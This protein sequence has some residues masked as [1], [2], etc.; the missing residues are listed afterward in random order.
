MPAPLPAR[1][2]QTGMRHG[3]VRRNGHDGAC[4]VKFAPD[5]GPT[6]DAD[7][8]EAVGRGDTT[9]FGEL[10]ER[11]RDWVLRLAYR[12]T[13]NERDTLEILHGTFARFLTTLPRLQMHAELS[14]FLYQGVTDLAAQ[15]TNEKRGT[16]SGEAAQPKRQKAADSI[17]ESDCPNGQSAMSG[18][19][20]PPSRTSE[21]VL[22]RRLAEDL[23]RLDDVPF[24]VPPAADEAIATLAWQECESIKARRRVRRWGQI[25]AIATA[26]FLAIAARSLWDAAKTRPHGV[27]AG[28]AAADVD[29]N[30]RVDMLDAFALERKIESGSRL[31]PRWDLNH[32][33]NVDRADVDAI[34][35]EAVRLSREAPQ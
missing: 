1:G 21:P 31:D 35:V 24:P 22:P 5:P 11:Y 14:S 32:D 20:Q 3:R 10:Y 27:E 34:A 30:G 16:D 29:R 28:P 33:G 13:G 17:S 12:L 9:A 6:P 26:V 15:L 2:C 18:T 8:V 25:A 4:M 23:A 7:L 19:R